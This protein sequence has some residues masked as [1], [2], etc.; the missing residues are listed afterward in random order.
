M[1]GAVAE[2]S[3]LDTYVLSRL[4][5]CVCVYVLGLSNMP[6]LCL[7]IVRFRSICR[8]FALPRG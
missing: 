3:M 4:Y 7:L 2:Y 6:G 5:V 1:R 8:L